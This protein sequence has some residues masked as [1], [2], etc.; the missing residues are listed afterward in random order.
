MYRFVA[1]RNDE[2]AIAMFM[3]NQ[4]RRETRA[5]GEKF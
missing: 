4:K 5:Y 1:D 2:Q 3:S